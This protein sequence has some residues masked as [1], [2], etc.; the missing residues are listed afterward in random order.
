MCSQAAAFKFMM[1]CVDQQS[2]FLVLDFMSFG[3]QHLLK[4]K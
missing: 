1:Y 3:T 2:V 4:W